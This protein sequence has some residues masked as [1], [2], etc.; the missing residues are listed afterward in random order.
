MWDLWENE[1]LRDMMTLR[2]QV[3]NAK[4]FVKV[5]VRARVTIDTS[6]IGMLDFMVAVDHRG[7]TVFAR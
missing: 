4:A 7:G 5:L 1:R 2:R 3:P 6:S